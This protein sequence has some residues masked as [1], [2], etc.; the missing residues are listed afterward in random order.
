MVWIVLSGPGK[1]CN[2]TTSRASSEMTIGRPHNEPNGPPTS[3]EATETKGH[4][5][6]PHDTA[7]SGP[8]RSARAGT[9]TW[10]TIYRD[11]EPH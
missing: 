10:N 7:V 3:P 2:P 9:S 1:I 4:Q 8:R 11:F 5:Q 6:Q